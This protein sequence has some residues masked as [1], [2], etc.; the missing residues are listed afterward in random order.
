M[1]NDSH[2]RLNHDNDVVVDDEDD[3]DY[4]YNFADKIKYQFIMI[5]WW[6]MMG[7]VGVGWGDNEVFSKW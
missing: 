2:F 3:D 4:H 7:E 5:Q 6:C 1:A